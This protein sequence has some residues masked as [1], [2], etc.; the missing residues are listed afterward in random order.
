MCSDGLVLISPSSASGGIT[1]QDAPVSQ[2]AALHDHYKV[3]LQWAMVKVEA[4]NPSPQIRCVVR[5]SPP[6]NIDW[7]KESVIISKGD[8]S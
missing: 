3:K 1:W 6:A 8:P 2:Y 4:L 7:L 5:A